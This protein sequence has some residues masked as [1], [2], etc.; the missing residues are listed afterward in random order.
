MANKDLIAYMDGKAVVDKEEIIALFS[1]NYEIPSYDKLAKSYIAS[2][3]SQAF[4]SVR[5]EKGR[6]VILAK[7]GKDGIQYVNIPACIDIVALKHIKKRILRDILGQRASLEKVEFR[8][9]VLKTGLPDGDPTGHS[10]G[11]QSAAVYS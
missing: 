4:A 7:R 5:D 2:K 1:D 8:I 10:G 6:R 3:I 9:D 11:E